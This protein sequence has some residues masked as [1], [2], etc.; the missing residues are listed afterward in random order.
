MFRLFK[1]FTKLETV[2]CVDSNNFKLM[3]V[4]LEHNYTYLVSVWL[5]GN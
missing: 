5:Y 2:F 4:R 3:P 1:S